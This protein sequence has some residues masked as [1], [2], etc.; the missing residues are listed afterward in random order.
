MVSKNVP[1]LCVENYMKLLQCIKTKLFIYS[2]NQLTTN[3]IKMKKAKRRASQKAKELA[4]NE[5]LLY[6]ERNIWS[7]IYKGL[8]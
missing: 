5:N 1:L 4:I 3:K 8:L 2:C 6:A 7:P